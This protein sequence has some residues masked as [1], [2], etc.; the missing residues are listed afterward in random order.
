MKRG[1]DYVSPPDKMDQGR[2]AGGVAGWDGGM[3]FEEMSPMN[4][5]V[6]VWAF[7]SVLFSVPV[8]RR[9]DPGSRILDPGPMYACMRACVYADRR[10]DRQAGRGIYVCIWL[11]SAGSGRLCRQVHTEVVSQSVL[12]SGGV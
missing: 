10:T 2:R 8:A 11:A 6:F 3:V 12:L 9:P 4:V 1:G 7:C 5:Y